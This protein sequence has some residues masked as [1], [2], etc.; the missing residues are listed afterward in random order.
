MKGFMEVGSD[1]AGGVYHWASWE[2]QW[3]VSA[4]ESWEE[5]LISGQVTAELFVLY[6]VSIIQNSPEKLPQELL[7]CSR[8][9]TE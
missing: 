7:L 9:L 3:V 8:L 2:L 6:S 1:S 5:T 4:H